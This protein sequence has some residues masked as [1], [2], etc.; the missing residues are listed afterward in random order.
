MRDVSRRSLLLAMLAFLGGALLWR[1]GPG[2]GA[3]AGDRERRLASTL[4]GL[5]APAAARRVGQQ[6]LR[7]VPAWRDEAVLR[8]GLFA[9]REAAGAARTLA[10]EVRDDLA[11]GRVVA[12]NGW[13]LSETEARVYALAALRAGAAGR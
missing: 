10:D 8:A 7:A 3:V 11:A 2:S 12:V 5:T 13:T 6:V 1:F 4:A 9:E